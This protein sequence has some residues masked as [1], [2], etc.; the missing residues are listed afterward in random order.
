MLRSDRARTASVTLREVRVTFHW[1]L[2]TTWLALSS[3]A[4][5]EA[6]WTIAFVQPKQLRIDGAVAEW[7]GAPWKHLGND[8]R[9]RAEVALAY[10]DDNLFVAARVFD[11]SF[12]RSAHPSPD[13]D[14][15]VLS[16]E[17]PATP[18]AR[19]VELWIYA[20]KMGRTRAQ[21]QLRDAG[22]AHPSELAGAQV[23]E[24]PG[25]HGET[26]VVEAQLP[27]KA[28]GSADWMFARGALRLHDVDPHAK[29]RDVSSSAQLEPLAFDRGPVAALA[30]LLEQ[31]EL[32]H[33]PK[34]L[35][36]TVRTRAPGTSAR[37]LVVGTLVVL[38]T[39]QGAIAYAE[40]PAARAADVQSAELRD[41]TGDGL[42]ELTVHATTRDSAATRKLWLVF[43]LSAGAPR[44]LFAAELRRERA[45]GSAEASLR[46]DKPLPHERAPRIVLGAGAVRGVG[47]APE[48]GP[49][50]SDV[51]PVPAASGAWSERVYVWDGARFTLRDERAATPPTAS[52]S[53]PARTEPSSAPAAASGAD[54]AQLTQAYLRARGVSA[55]VQPRFVQR[56]NV[57]EDSRP[58]QLA[59]YDRECL[60]VGPGFRGGSDFFYFA[61]PVASAEQVSALWTADVTGDQ[62]HEILARVTSPASGVTR[63]LLM[64]YSFHSGNF[65]TLLVAEVGRSIG[66]HAIQNE[67]R[68]LPQKGRNALQIRP[69]TARSW[70]ATTYP[71][72]DADSQAEIAPLLLPWSDRARDY[73]YDGKRLSPC[74][75]SD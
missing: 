30:A 43:E 44:Q 34:L 75:G 48:L 15:L 13:E 4:R 23:I 27:W 70:T 3:Q 26:Y 57:A 68:V 71:Y 11:D 29:A 42:P 55:A 22:H 65:E 25:T 28:L 62:R 66:G 10:D 47:S 2:L 64:V 45:G 1:A 73:C 37:V 39:A 74:P 35:D 67:V 72:R 52:V 60:I 7:S 14:A 49:A 19:R 56:A 5:A 46:V 9:G 18:D 12:V 24:G 63:E 31:R 69:G 61:L 36:A 40:L 50:L 8:A 20:G 16:L 58:E 41:L 53:E 32:M 6:P 51:V 54:N 59:L 38:A 17:L 33:A 21:A